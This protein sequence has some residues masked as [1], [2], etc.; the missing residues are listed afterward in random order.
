MFSNRNIEQREMKLSEILIVVVLFSLLMAVFITYFLKTKERVHEVGFKNLTNNFISKVN[1]VHGQWLIDNKPDV[2]FI[3]FSPSPL[4]NLD[5]QVE[6]I[7]VNKQGWI[8]VL[9]SEGQK[10]SELDIA[11]QQI[12]HFAL[13]MPM[14]YM[15]EPISVVEVIKK[16]QNS[17]RIC[18]Y[19]IKGGLYFE[20]H[21]QNGKV[22]H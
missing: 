17:S 20:Y 5:K 4:N 19:S 6:K 14:V 10:K 1:L 18:R 3:A 13:N 16:P 11:C 9:A 7:P 22:I 21:S 2:V 15:N 12:W 8:D